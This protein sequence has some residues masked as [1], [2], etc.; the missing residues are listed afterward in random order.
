MINSLFVENL[1]SLENKNV[2][3]KPITVLVGKNSSGKSSFLRVFPLL[4]QSTESKTLGPIL[5]FGRYV[6]YGAFSEAKARYEKSN[7]IKFGFNISLDFNML[8]ARRRRHSSDENVDIKVKLSVSDK[9]TRQSSFLSQI[10]INI[11]NLD[12]IMKF[13]NNYLSSFTI[14]TIEILEMKNKNEIKID[15]AG[16]SFIP[17]ILQKNKRRAYNEKNEIIFIEDYSAI[18]FRDFISS[19]GVDFI[20]KYFWHT[21]HHETISDAFDS[22]GFVT[23]DKLYER[24]LIEFKNQSKFLE[25]CANKEIK[26]EIYEDLH[27]SMILNNFTDLLTT[28]D[29]VLHE[30]FSSVKYL[31]PLRSTAQRY[32]RFQ[33]LQVNE[34]DHEGSN[35]AMFIYSLTERERKVLQEWTQKSLGFIVKVISEGLHYSLLIKLNDDDNEYNISDMGFGFSQILPIVITLW[36]EIFRPTKIRRRFNTTK[37]F[38]IEQPE[39]HLHP[40]MQVKLSKLFVN[41]VKYIKIKKIDVRIIFETHSNVMIEALGESI[42]E[43]DIDK[44]DVSI[45]IFDKE[46]PT[47]KTNIKQ[48]S[49]DEKGYLVDWPI[50][51]FSGNEYGN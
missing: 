16:R 8:N 18:S 22:I 13:E 1:R 29:R 15:Y 26:N 43:K 41:I 35:I 38:V 32:Y 17:R 39:L 31:A 27:I 48:T 7:Y 10:E 21:T 36:T 49:F 19:L 11:E 28:V 24:V 20:K 40:N 34:I 37:Y 6:D 51:F 5:W 30:S 23:K 9:K 45:I 12:F 2:N 14:N 33:D 50:G 46:T 4:R 44:N 42:E 3:L 25:N 47:S